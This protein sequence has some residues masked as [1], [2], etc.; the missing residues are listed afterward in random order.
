MKQ[1]LAVIL[2][3]AAFVDPTLADNPVLSITGGTGGYPV[4]NS[5]HGWE[6][7]VNEAITVTHL[8]LYDD[9][10]D[11][12]L[13]DHPIGVFRLSDSQLLTSG[14]LNSGTEDT[15]VDGF[16]YIDTPD[17]TLDFGETYVISF[18]STDSNDLDLTLSLSGLSVNPA[19]TLKVPA[20]WETDTGGLVLPSN[21]A[22]ALFDPYRIGPNFQF[23]VVPE[24][25][26]FTLLGLASLALL[27]T[28]KR[29]L[30]QTIQQSK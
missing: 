12:L 7:V 17:V 3:L 2:G 27:T 19:I 9:G 1:A 18:Y 25:T 29:C 6:F 23:T 14:T 26:T 28:R 20:R 30:N 4:A 21:Y 13:G 11:G 10:N 16:R 22:D 8:G 5:C 15:L 24:P